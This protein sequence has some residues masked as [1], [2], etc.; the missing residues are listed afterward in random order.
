MLTYNDELKFIDMKGQITDILTLN[1]DMYYDY[2]KMYQ[3]ILGIEKFYF[4]QL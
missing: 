1:G 3:S 2:G 4:Q